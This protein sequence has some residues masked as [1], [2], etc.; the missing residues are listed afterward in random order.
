[1]ENK[2]KPWWE[3]YWKGGTAFSLQKFGAFNFQNRCRGSEITEVW[4][5][6]QLPSEIIGTI[7]NNG[8]VPDDTSKEQPI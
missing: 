1:M 5:L 6:R 8:V 3:T 4:I 2:L 7:T